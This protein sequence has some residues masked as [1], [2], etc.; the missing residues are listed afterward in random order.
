VWAASGDVHMEAYKRHGGEWS[1]RSLTLTRP[2]QEPVNL[3]SVPERQLAA[4]PQ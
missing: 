1:I 4:P 2:G 3:S